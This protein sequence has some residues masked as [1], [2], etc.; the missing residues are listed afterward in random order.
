MALGFF[1]F[2][3]VVVMIFFVGAGA[4]GFLFCFV[5]VVAAA[6]FASVVLTDDFVVGRVVD[7]VVMIFFVGAGA[8]GFLFGFAVVVTTVAVFASVV[9]T[10]DFVVGRVVDLRNLAPPG[11]EGGVRDVD[12]FFLGGMISSWVNGTTMI[13]ITEVSYH[14]R[15]FVTLQQK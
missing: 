9:L 8:L 7:L 13:E 2:F 6:V 3:V 15:L 14:C 5:V 4:L 12:V 10:D 1:C 11:G